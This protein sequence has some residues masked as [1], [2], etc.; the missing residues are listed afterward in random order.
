VVVSIVHVHKGPLSVLYR[1]DDRNVPRITAYLFHAGGHDN[2]EKLKANTGRSFLGSKIYGQGFVFD[3]ADPK[4]IASPI[5]DMHRLIAKDSRNTE[6]ILPYIGGDEVNDSPTHEH[7]RYV[8]NFAEM[9]E[10]EARRW[11]DLMKTVEE[12]VKPERAKLGGNRDAEIRRERW[13]LWGRYTPALFDA[14]RGLERVIVCSLHQPYWL[15]SM[16]RSDVVFS[17]ALGIFA[18]EKYSSFCVLQSRAH[19]VWARFFGS[20]MKDDLRYTPSD[21]FETF[22]F[23]QDFEASPALEAVGRK[24]YELRAALMVRNNEG[25]TKTYNCF[26]DPDERSPDIL[27]LRELHA[28]MDRAVL[29]AYG[30]TD[31]KP[32][33]EFL[34]DYEEDEDE[35]GTDNSQLT[36]RRRRKPWRYR[37]PDD[38]RDEVL[39][40]LLELNRQRAEEERLSGAAAEAKAKKPR[41]TPRKKSRSSEPGL[42]NDGEPSK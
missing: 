13:W 3:D 29:D 22:P 10:Q 1:L 21:C 34:L 11:P 25:L 19:E 41:K 33:C 37:W 15:I 42:F 32:T 5:A 40:R 2:P 24:Y 4:G 23:P 12:K 27:K 14:I 7:D 30:W 35:L 8:I 17:H 9:S 6:R 31:L 16:I 26:H 36:T 20:S 18:F 39:A 38:F 28:A